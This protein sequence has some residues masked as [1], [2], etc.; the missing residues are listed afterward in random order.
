MD[1]LD[2]ALTQT[3]DVIA[4][5]RPEQAGLPTP[6]SRWTVQA[7][8]SHVV[9]GASVMADM[10]RGGSWKPHEIDVPP[11]R[12]SADF[13]SSAGEL[14]MA[15]REKDELDEAATNRLSQ[16]IA[17]F[18]VHSWDIARATGQAEPPDDDVAEYALVWARR[19][20]KPE[21]RGDEGS[22]MAFGREQPAP[23][24]APAIDQLAAFFGRRL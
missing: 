23:E 17:E 18:A 21:H 7:L 1:L 14:L 5:V 16:A 9:G 8:I 3:G 6:C 22:G 13:S 15:W 4:R 11:D 19:S 2:R 12:W 10:A 20:L 24:G